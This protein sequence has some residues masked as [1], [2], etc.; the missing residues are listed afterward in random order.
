VPSHRLA[1]S[2]SH[3]L[4]VSPH[5]QVSTAS[6]L[7]TAFGCGDGNRWRSCILNRG[8]GE[9]V[10]ALFVSPVDDSI[11]VSYFDLHQ[12]RRRL[13]CRRIHLSAVQECQASGS[14]HPPRSEELFEGRMLE[15]PG[16]LSRPRVELR[17]SEHARALCMLVPPRIDDCMHDA[18]RRCRTAAAAQ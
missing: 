4:A 15:F 16:A 10:K 12:H 5:T 14:V 2:P 6:G 8:A 17:L 13:Q 7:S 1:V 11:L 18:G 3:R 9:F